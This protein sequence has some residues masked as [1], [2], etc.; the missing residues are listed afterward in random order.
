MSNY[1]LN[2]IDAATLE[3]TR[4]KILGDIK[5]TRRAVEGMRAIANHFDGVYCTRRILPQLT[6]LFPSA[7][8]VYMGDPDFVGNIY[9]TVS[10]GYPD[11]DEIFLCK[12]DNRRIDGAELNARAEKQAVSAGTSEDHLQRI[13]EVVSAYNTIAADYAEI[14]EDMREWFSDIPYADYQ[15][16]NQ[17]KARRKASDALT[18]RMFARKY[19]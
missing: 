16:Q 7:Q 11:S 5:R 2:A 8:H 14:Y 18:L 19:A 10:Y 12:A 13:E 9:L 4:T 3:T 15:L 6:A 17:V 1:S